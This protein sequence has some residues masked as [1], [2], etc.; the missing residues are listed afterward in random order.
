MILKGY[1]IHKIKAYKGNFILFYGQNQGLKEEAI[2]KIQTENKNRAV[3]KYDE[4]EF[5]EKSETSY[6]NILSGSLF[7]DKKIIIISRASDKI[8]NSINFFQEKKLD[9]I[10]IIIEAGNLDKKSKLRSL[11]EKNKNFICVAFYTD[12]QETLSKIA[13]NFLIENNIKISQSNLNLIV[14]KCNGDRGVLKNELNKIQLYLKN[15]KT[16]ALDDL[17]KLTNL[18]ENHS[19]SELV[20][21]CLAQNKNKTLLMLN[22]NILSVEDCVII[23][24]TFL[25]KIKRILN[26]VKAY[27]K[28]KNLD[29]T[30]SSAK[31]PIFWKD[32][33]IIK[34]QINKWKLA[35]ISK[36]LGN[37]NQIEL[38]IKK[39]KT[40]PINIVRNFIIE[41][42]SLPINSKF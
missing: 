3:I 6:E 1:E 37:V 9:D 23:T 17:M 42:I 33:E 20:D 11:F 27:Q 14:N 5:L 31:P 34:Q 40:D 29:L 4:K 30:I 36:L 26:L 10:L 7:E 25:Q 16:L 38:L 13:Y 32:K 22:E 12:T 8:L 35:D 18:L 24:R 21:N 28:N 41:T 39:N 2:L 15:K 19:I